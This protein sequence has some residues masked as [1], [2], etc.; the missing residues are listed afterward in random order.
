M[1]NATLD[2][3]QLTIG[4]RL[5][6]W[7]ADP[8]PTL[9]VRAPAS[10]TIRQVNAALLTLAAEIEMLTPPTERWVV[11]MSPSSAGSASRGCV[12][13]ELF[14]PNNDFAELDRA[15]RLLSQLAG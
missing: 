13:I 8:Y 7:R 15:M 10:W 14:D 11:R 2:T 12:Y 6:R 4:L 1:N 5:G 3:T 9:D